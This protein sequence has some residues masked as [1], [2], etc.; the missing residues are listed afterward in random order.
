[1]CLHN[2]M[3][4]SFTSALFAMAYTLMIIASLYGVKGDA[5]LADVV[6]LVRLLIYGLI[7][8]IW[9]L[10]T[11]S[12]FKTD[13]R[14]LIF[15][16]FFFP[17]LLTNGYMAY[18]D[19]L[20]ILIVAYQISRLPNGQEF[21]VKLAYV[22]LF[23]VVCCAGAAEFGF[24]TT[25]VFEFGERAKATYGFGN[26][27]NL[28]Y[29]VFTS[30]FIFYRWRIAKGF[31]IC[32]LV[33]VALYPSV[34]SRTFMIAYLLLAAFWTANPKWLRSSI[35]FFLWCWLGGVLAFGLLMGLFPLEVSIALSYIT[36]IDINE[37][38]SNR[39]EII[40]N[41]SAGRTMLSI[42]WGGVENTADSLYVYLANGFGVGGLI[43]FE[44]L[45]IALVRKHL[46]SN[47][48]RAL[49]MA[50]VYLTVAL[51]EAPYS[52]SAL[53]AVFFI[54]MLLYRSDLT[55]SANT[56]PTPHI[57]EVKGT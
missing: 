46:A 35:I 21:F 38:I 36:G 18:I 47:N 37:L 5:M 13:K 11:A 39:L 31:F 25:T 55:S 43:L 14:L 49:T 56:L 15:A 2:K 6:F 19:T 57:P 17:Y 12:A 34:D 32:G 52:G 9:I 44:L 41:R 7:F 54:S 29:Y 22:S 3:K 20:I 51:V 23:L 48:V 40:N 16:I 45:V 53:I 10:S 27:N 24:I 4:A 42:L 1:M 30:A 50:C 28:Y 33:L 8:I 26:P